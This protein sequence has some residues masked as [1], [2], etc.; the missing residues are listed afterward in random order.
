MVITR[1]KNGAPDMIL[2][3]FDVKFRETKNG[4]PPEA[5]RPLTKLKKKQCRKSDPHKV[6]QNNVEKVGPRKVCQY[7]KIILHL[8]SY[9]T[10][11]FV[12]RVPPAIV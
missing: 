2:T 7:I 4:M 3:A 5:C 9:E 6:K 1:V 12:N 10:I 11:I 8:A